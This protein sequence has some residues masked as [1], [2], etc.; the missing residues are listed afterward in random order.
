MVRQA[1][2]EILHGFRF[3]IPA[4]VAGIA[5]DAEKAVRG[6]EGGGLFQRRQGAA[7][8][9]DRFFIPAR[10]VAQVE[11]DGLHGTG[12]QFRQA[13]MAGQMEVDGGGEQPFFLQTLPGGANG[14]LLHVKGV[15]LAGRA[16]QTGQENR[17]VSVACR[18]VHDRIPGQDDAA[19]PVMRAGHGTAEQGTFHD[20][21]L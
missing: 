9:G 4:F 2:K 13:V 21:V 3:R 6:D 17:V 19:D 5:H 1:G 11:D 12:D 15:H 16:G 20:R 18:G 8:S 14:F 7:R 10:Q